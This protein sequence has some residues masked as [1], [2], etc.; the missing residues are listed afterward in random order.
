[1][2][3]KSSHEPSRGATRGRIA[4]LI[5]DRQGRGKLVAPLGELVMVSQLSPLA[6]RRQIDR[7]GSRVVRLPG[8]PTVYL[9]VPNEDRVRGAPPVAAWLHDYL[10]LRETFYYVGLLSAAALHGS[11]AQATLVSQVLV[12]TIR[13]PTE[14][15][16]TRIE[17][18]T[19]RGLDTTPLAAVAGLPAPLNVSSP[20]ATVFD[21][22]AYSHR[23]GG[24]VRAIEV[25]QGLRPTLS[26]GG[27]NRAVGA[28]VPAT[29]LQRA[30]YLFETLGW[31][32]LADAVERALPAR[33]PA[34]ALQ[35]RGRVTASTPDSRWVVVDNIQLRRGVRA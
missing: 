15:G 9:T 10:R 24:I 20:E 28:G 21:L 6:V 23:I 4:R 2:H 8:R 7:L 3:S 12:P 22:I 26:I 30:G 33:F 5:E 35:T 14:I 25:T 34:T 32:P 16:R 17:F 11:T 18:I 1:M 29:I 31:A 13:R 27:L 19:K